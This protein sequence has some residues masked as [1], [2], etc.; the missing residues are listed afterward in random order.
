MQYKEHEIRLKTINTKHVICQSKFNEYGNEICH[1]IKW[2]QLRKFGW[3]QA[4]IDAV[5]SGA[6]IRMHTYKLLFKME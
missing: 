2:F 3:C 5:N 6:G 4:F 1:A